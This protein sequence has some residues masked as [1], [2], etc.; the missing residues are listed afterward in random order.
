MA[1][2]AK[3]PIRQKMFQETLDRVSKSGDIENIQRWSFWTPSQL[4]LMGLAENLPRVMLI[5]GNGTGKTTILETFAMKTAMEH[6]EENIF[7]G[8]QQFYT[9][10][11]PLLELQIQVKF[12]QYKNFTVLRFNNIDELQFLNRYLHFSR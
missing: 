5:G 9:S 12:E 3:A 1:C 6:S 2:A 4:S 10:A 7:F 11:R 8:I